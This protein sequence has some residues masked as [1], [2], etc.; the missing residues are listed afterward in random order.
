VRR[1]VRDQVARRATIAE[2][3]GARLS[4]VKPHGALYNQAAVDR[5]LA[6]AIARGVHDVD[7]VYRLVGLEGSCLL[8]EGRAAGLQ[9]W[10]EG[11]I[12]RAYRADGTLVPRPEPGALLT[13]PTLAV[14]QAL[15]MLLT[16]FVRAADGVSRVAVQ[17]DTLCVHA[18]TP[19]AIDLVRRLHV[20][21]ADKGIGIGEGMPPRRWR[22]QDPHAADTASAVTRVRFGTRPPQ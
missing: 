9:V 17:P 2:E 7:P 18:D 1:L 14:T 12:D 22:G 20:A 19:G 11:F 3:R 5:S 15:T 16:G 6:A 10:G 8:E 4:H 21:L 13:D